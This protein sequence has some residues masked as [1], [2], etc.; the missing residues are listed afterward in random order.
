MLA[1]SSS[2]RAKNVFEAVLKTVSP[3]VN[4]STCI[5]EACGHAD[6]LSRSLNAAFEDV[7]DLMLSV[8]LGSPVE[9]GLSARTDFDNALVISSKERQQG[10]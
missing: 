5:D 9:M 3:Q 7:A 4:I 1:V 10:P 2:C 6:T 8:E